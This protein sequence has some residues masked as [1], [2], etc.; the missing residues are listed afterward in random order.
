MKNSVDRVKGI[1]NFTRTEF[2]I[3]THSAKDEKYSEQTRNIKNVKR[4][5]WKKLSLPQPPLG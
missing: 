3:D 5:V 2:N 4:K 1:D